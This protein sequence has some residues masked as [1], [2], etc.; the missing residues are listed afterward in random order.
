MKYTQY[1]RTSEDQKSE[2]EFS[3]SPEEQLEKKLKNGPNVEMK[4]NMDPFDLNQPR[5]TEN[6][7]I[8]TIALDTKVKVE[9]NDDAIRF[10]PDDFGFDSD[11]IKTEIKEEIKVEP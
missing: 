3:V 10:S 9:T 6:K 8:Q 11:T 4:T 2:T 5:K 1:Y 7:Y